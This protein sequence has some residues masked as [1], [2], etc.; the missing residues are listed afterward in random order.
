VTDRDMLPSDPIPLL[1]A[2]VDASAYFALACLEPVGP[3]LCARSSF[4]DPQGIV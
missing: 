2:S 4:V 3:Y 1:F